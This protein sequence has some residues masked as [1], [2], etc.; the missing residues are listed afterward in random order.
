MHGF[1]RFR[2]VGTAPVDGVEECGTD[3][4][5]EPLPF[6][7]CVR[8]FPTGGRGACAGA[9]AMEALTRVN[10]SIERLRD[11]LESS[12]DEEGPRAA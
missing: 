1:G 3:D 9:R 7:T 5:P 4:L 12:H 10:F 6:P 11:A 8:D 2:L